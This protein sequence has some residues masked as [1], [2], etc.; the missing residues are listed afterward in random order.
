MRIVVVAAHPDDETVGASAVLGAPHDTTVIHVTDGAP[1]DPRWWPSGV[2]DRDDYA[3]VRALEATRALALA[4]VERVPLGFVDQ[5]A[6]ISMRGLAQALAAQIE[7]LAPDV[8]VTHAYEGG[9]PDHDAVA[10]AVARARRL[11]CADTRLYEMAL[12]HAGPGALVTGAFIDDRGSIR[13]DLA[14]ARQ[15]RRRAML[16]CFASQRTTLAPFIELAH[17][18]YRSAPEYDFSRP[19]HDGPLHYERAGFPMTGTRWRALAAHA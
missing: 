6:S 3:R 11:A 12:Y 18:R 13:H 19:P 16:D 15:R 7:R 4:G 5:E 2:V 9:H 14:P 10:F 17:E 8:I 1:R